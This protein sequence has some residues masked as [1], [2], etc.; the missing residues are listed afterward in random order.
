MTLKSESL[1]EGIH[2]TRRLFFLKNFETLKS[3]LFIFVRRFFWLLFIHQSFTTS[4]PL[5]KNN[6]KMLTNSNKNDLISLLI[7]PKNNVSL[8]RAP[9]T[10]K[11]FPYPD[12]ISQTPK[13][14]STYLVLIESLLCTFEDK[15]TKVTVEGR[16]GTESFR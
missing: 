6:F 8:E 1:P 2:Q 5:F 14:F 12:S 4:E 13:Q 16:G 15:T 3:L 11:S 9:L 10:F 7:T